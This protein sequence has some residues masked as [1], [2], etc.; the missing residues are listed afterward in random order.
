MLARTGKNLIRDPQASRV[1]VIQAII[2]SILIILVFW[3][4]GTDTEGVNGKAGYLFFI[5]I[6]Q[7]MTALFSVLLTFLS[8]RPVFLREYA[9]KM[10]GIWPYFFSKSIV[11]VPFQACVPFLTAVITYFAVGLTDDADRFFL[12]ACVLI[13][14]VFCAT[15]FGFF[16][17]CAVTNESAANALIS[18]M[19][20][21][22]ILF[23]GYFVNLD[24]VYVWLRWIQYISPIRY[25]TEAL[26]RIEFEDN[27]RYTLSEQPYD[28]YKYDVGLANCIIILAVL[29]IVF[30]MLALVFLKITVSRVQ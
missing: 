8:E 17:G 14:D 13:L 22:F 21:P 18:L 19:I 2:M 28:T 30:R 29:S 15:S 1:R 23:A 9:N 25:S 16:V 24:D 10:Y 3:D 5:S 7:V 27:N 11:E 4:M 20:L 12:H 6:N 26:V